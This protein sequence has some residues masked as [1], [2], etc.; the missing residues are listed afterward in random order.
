MHS[1]FYVN[2][3]PVRRHWCVC[4]AAMQFELPPPPRS[5]LVHDECGPARRARGLTPVG[6][7]TTIRWETWRRVTDG[8][9]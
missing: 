5:S 1:G 8:G 2:S 6:G 9:R 7:R 3:L 4:K